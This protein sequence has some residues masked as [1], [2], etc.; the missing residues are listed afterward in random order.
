MRGAGKPGAGKKYHVGEA[1]GRRAADDG[2]QGFVQPGRQ[3]AQGGHRRP[4]DEVA[5]SHQDQPGNQPRCRAFPE[6]REI[7]RVIEDPPDIV[8]FGKTAGDS[9]KHCLNYTECEPACQW[10]FPGGEPP[11][12]MPPHRFRP[13][14]GTGVDRCGFARME[15]QWIPPHGSGRSG[16]A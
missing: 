5:E 3:N 6:F 9:L 14:V 11:P 15:D 13:L 10:Y 4:A 2:D 7:C 8:R 16:I 1:V 12:G